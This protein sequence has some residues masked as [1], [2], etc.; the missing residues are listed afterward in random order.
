MQ[1]S[2]SNLTEMDKKILG[3]F[4]SGPGRD[5]FLTLSFDKICG[6]LA[7]RGCPPLSE[8][9]ARIDFLCGR[10][11]LRRDENGDYQLALEAIKA[12]Y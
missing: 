6:E 3:A 8:V 12:G 1:E 2:L 5:K 9:Q 11:Y 7:C 4:A 10:G